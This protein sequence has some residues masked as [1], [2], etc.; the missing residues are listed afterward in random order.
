MGWV[1]RRKQNCWTGDSLGAEF[2]YGPVWEQPPFPVS[3]N[4]CQRKERER[5]TIMTVDDTEERQTVNIG[6]A[7][8]IM[9]ETISDNE[10][11]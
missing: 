4:S 6:D 11:E 8:D 5:S 2:S 7:P 10:K 9:E 1:L 3:R